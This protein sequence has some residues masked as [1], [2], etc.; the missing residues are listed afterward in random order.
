[1]AEITSNILNKWS[2]LSFKDNVDI[3]KEM[4]GLPLDIVTGCVFG[5]GMMKN[6]HLRE[7][8][9][10]GVATRL[11]DIEHRTYNMIGIIPI[12]NQL[13]LPSK[14]RID[15][16]KQNV[17]Y[18]VQHIID[19]RKKGLSKSPCKGL[20]YFIDDLFSFFHRT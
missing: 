3:H 7:I 19:E 5:S 17:K 14:R 2:S 20:F 1:M 18:A 8:I 12:I 13:P 4:T 10:Q 16:S 11:E 6:E 15:K 9:H